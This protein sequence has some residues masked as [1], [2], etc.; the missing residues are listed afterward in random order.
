[1]APLGE[2]PHDATPEERM[3]VLGARAVA[4]CVES[5]APSHILAGIGVSSL[6]VWLAQAGHESFPRLI[7]EVGFYDYHPMPGNPFLFYFP[8]IA[9][10]SALT[11]TY[12]VLG[13]LVQGRGS[14]NLAVLAGAQVDRFGNINTTR[15]ATGWLTGS[16]GANDIAMG[17]TRNIVLIP[18]R[19][20]RLV[21]QVDYVTSP[22]DH[23]QTVV[24][25]RAVFIKSGHRELTLKAV[26]A[27]PAD[28]DAAVEQVIRS[29][30]WRLDLEPVVERCD[31]P[32]QLEL[33]SVRAFDPH[34]YF[35]GKE[36]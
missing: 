23:V 9:T 13:T 28:Y 33:S 26:M 36:H 31:E 5:D 16:G 4:N 18:H 22:G 35:L 34:R 8:N 30:P 14:E 6:A 15:T 24:T 12:T 7:S 25:D 17:S 11:D 10:C 1:V 20:G 3:I 19:A 32:T 29:T 2:H 21:A 27:A